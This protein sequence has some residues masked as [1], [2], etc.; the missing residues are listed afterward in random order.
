MRSEKEIDSLYTIKELQEK[1]SKVHRWFHVVPLGTKIK[2]PG[3]Y[4]M[5]IDSWISGLLPS[6]LSGKNI[7][8]IGAYDG[9]WT[10]ECEK[11]N[12]K[13]ITAI[14]VWQ[15]TEDQGRLPFDVC[16]EILGSTS[17]LVEMSVYDIEKLNEK[18][19][20]V[21]YLGVYYHLLDPMHALKK[22]YDV[23]KDL[24]IMEGAVLETDRSLCYALKPREIS[25]DPT[26]FY[27]FSPTFL[28]RCAL[29]LGFKKI[30][31]KGY[32]LDEGWPL[33][34]DSEVIDNSSKPLY[35]NRGLFYLWK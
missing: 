23:C 21:L 24:V 8:D 5:S 11:R 19:D 28:E 14:D 30:E 32:G 17:T 25:G 9:R 7:L 15:Y 29:S 22:I 16:K 3:I 13:K 18:F 1:I 12:A 6:D 2:T 35:H 31:F 34:S 26:N 33:H 27:L 4:D 10:F 20:L